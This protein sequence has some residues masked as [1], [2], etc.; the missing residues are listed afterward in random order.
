M[1]KKSVYAVL[2]LML[3]LV[4]GCGEDKKMSQE[5]AGLVYGA[6]F[7]AAGTALG[8]I[9]SGIATSGGNAKLVA[10]E[11]SF[12]YDPETGSFSGTVQSAEGG[13]AN[14]TGE[15]TVSED[16]T[17]MNYK[18]DLDFIDWVSTGITLNGIISIVYEMSGANFSWNM[19]GDLN[20]SGKVSGDVNFDI[21]INSDGTYEGTVGGYEMGGNY[22]E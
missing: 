15:Y 12:T 16:Q 20:A 19:T 2:V 22:N 9:Q 10:D 4:V 13:M 18:F 7:N 1:F 11:G 6:A 5:D 21:T 8:Q 3:L 14:I 17:T